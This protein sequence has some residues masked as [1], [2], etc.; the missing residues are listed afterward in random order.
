MSEVLLSPIMPFMLYKTFMDI[1]R[2]SSI[3]V[4]ISSRVEDLNLVLL[5]NLTYQI[6]PTDVN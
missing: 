6:N 2:V 4:R 1:Y 5:E 3:Y